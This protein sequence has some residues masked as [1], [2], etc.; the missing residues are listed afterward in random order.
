MRG[1]LLAAVALTAGA[2]VAAGADELSDLKSQL[3]AATKSIQTLQKRVQ[4]LEGQRAQGAQG[5]LAEAPPAGHKPPPLVK[6]TPA[7]PLA[8]EAPVIAPNE[9]P[10]VRVAGPERPRL[11]LYGQAQLDMI[12]D[13]KKMDPAWAGAFRP[14]KIPVNCPPVGDDAGCGTN[15]LTTFSVRQSKFGAKGFLPTTDGEV[16]TQFEFDLF[17]QGANAGQ[18]MF[19]LQQAWGSWGPVLAGYTDSVFMDGSIFPNIIDYWGPSGMIYVKTPQLRWTPYEQEG[20]TFAVAL[21][22]PGFSGDLGRVSEIVPE[23]GLT[24]RTKTQ[25]PDLTAHLRHEGMWGHV[26]LAGVARWITFDNTATIGG[27]PSGTVFGWGFNLSG[28]LKTFGDD[29]LHAQVAYGKGIAAYSNDCCIDIAPTGILPLTGGAVPLLDWL[30]YYDH[31]WT[32]KWSSSIGFSQ[33]IQD[34]LPLQLGT[35]EHIGS[36]AS[37]NLLYKPIQN[38]MVGVEGLW[39]ERTNKDGSK[40]NDQRIQV[41]TQYKY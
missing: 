35:D 18:T 26:Q 23:F 33:N 34:T 3:E 6:A 38:V 41:S 4:S 20:T 24:E 16:K 30:V 14:S 29:A 1:V 9:K 22:V 21:E 7:P 39:G 11:E 37:I 15:G 10:E 27:A 32:A 36:Y 40:A 8:L 19:H 28:S 12:Y 31:Y 5:A 25:Y 13:T 17:G 2:P